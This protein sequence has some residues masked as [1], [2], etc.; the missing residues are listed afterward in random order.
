MFIRGFPLFRVYGDLHLFFAL[1]THG[2]L[3]ISMPRLHPRPI[4]SEPS[5]EETKHQ[6]FQH[7]SGDCHMQLCWGAQLSTFIPSHSFTEHL[8]TETQD[9]PL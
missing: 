7:Y 9:L 1:Y 3:E 4:I 8:H 5:R 6:Y 2:G